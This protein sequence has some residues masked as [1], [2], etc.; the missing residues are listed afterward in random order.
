MHAPPSEPPPVKYNSNIYE[1]DKIVTHK[2]GAKGKILYKCRWTGYGPKD[3][4]W[5]P[6]HQL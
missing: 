4:T 5:E 3:D 2:K 1:L 6:P